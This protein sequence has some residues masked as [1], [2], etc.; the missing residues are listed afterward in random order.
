MMV[1]E[2]VLAA[3]ARIRSWVHHTPLLRSHLL[4]EY[5][6]L[7][8]FFKAEHLQKTGSFKVRG[9]L[10]F[11][12][13]EGGS[14]TK[15]ATYS[16][17]NHGQA[18]AWAASLLNK[19][20]V[21]FMPKDASE[22]KIAAV[23]GYGA[24]V[25]FAGH[26]TEDRRRA[27]EAFA[28]EHDSLIIPPYDH[29]AIVAGQ[30]TVMLEIL[31]DQP[32]ID[33]VLVPTGGGGLASGN[34]LV[35]KGIRQKVEI[36]TCE[37]DSAADAKAS[38]EM[39]ALQHR[40]LST[41]IADGLRSLSL[42]QLNWELLHQYADGGLVCDEAAIREAM[43]L[44]ASYLKQWVEPS[45]AVSLACILRNR[46]QFSGKRV[47]LIISGGNISVPDFVKVVTVHGCHS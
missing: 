12:L 11:V 30:G 4:S 26:T 8:L 46:E 3:K 16:S 19:Q 24:R 9:V 39:G 25:H 2:D 6:G 15:I 43:R 27:C 17:G 45:G 13:S 21:V 10:N 22:A 7:D 42:G 31:T 35:L 28:S 20:P 18:V 33:A 38:L 37:P 36:Y 47:V 34:A 14:Y 5:L 1:L 40:P 23:K 44:Y 29:P 32:D 41:T